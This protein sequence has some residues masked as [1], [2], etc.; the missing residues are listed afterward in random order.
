MAETPVTSADSPRITLGFSRATFE[1]R[2]A[3]AKKMQIVRVTR[4]ERYR[5]IPFSPRNLHSL[6]SYT[7]ESSSS[8]FARR[9]KKF[10]RCVADI[11]YDGA[12][13]TAGKYDWRTSKSSDRFVDARYLE[14]RPRAR[15]GRTKNLRSRRGRLK[16]KEDNDAFREKR[17]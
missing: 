13:S 10:G 5:A 6:L 12:C 15:D 14:S 17:W 8:L 2:P 3:L 16:P 4:G 9:G 7:T 11:K 1:G